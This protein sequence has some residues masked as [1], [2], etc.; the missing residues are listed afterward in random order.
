MGGV[1]ALL[2]CGIVSVFDISWW[3]GCAIGR[4]P[5]FCLGVLCY[6]DQQESR[7]NYKWY[8][9]V[10]LL[11][12]ALSVFL[13]LKG[14]N[15][16]GFFITDMVAPTLMLLIA[17]LVSRFPIMVNSK[18]GGAIEYIGTHSLEIYVANVISELTWRLYFGNSIMGLVVY[19]LLNTVLAYLL[20]LFNDQLS[21]IKII[22]GEN[23]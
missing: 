5:I 1:I 13:Y 21:K 17:L 3:Y 20:I 15:M 9:L 10:F 4:I 16:R 7:N 2:I 11:V 6:F 18:M 19:L 14:T 12:F 22:S 23:K 8:S